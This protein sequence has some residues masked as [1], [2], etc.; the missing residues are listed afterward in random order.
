MGMTVMSVIDC[1]ARTKQ[2]SSERT[3]FC[4]CQRTA[5][6][7]LCARSWWP[8]ESRI[9]NQGRGSSRWARA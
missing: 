7:W 9:C 2:V 8:D 1:G 5:R 4:N 6:P 3:M